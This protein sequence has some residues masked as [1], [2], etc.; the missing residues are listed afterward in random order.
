MLTV[1]IPAYNAEN[2]ISEQLE[3][4]K[5]QCYEGDWE[6]IVVNNGSTDN[7]V[8]IVAGY[9]QTMP[10]LKLAHALG[11]QS[12]GYA[13][14]RGVQNACGDAF[15]FCDADD[16]AAPNWIKAMAEALQT[17]DVVAGALEDRVLNQYSVWRPP[18][19][20]N[21]IQK[22][23][24]KNHLDFLPFALGCNLAISRDAFESVGG[25]VECENFVCEDVDLSWRLQ[26]QGYTIHY[27]PEAIMHYRF[28]TTY[29]AYWRQ[30]AA[31]A[32]CAPLLYKRF[33][34]YGMPEP[35]V[36][37]ALDRYIWVIKKFPRALVT[38]RK[39]VRSR[40][41]FK[42]AASWGRIQ[43]SIRHKVFYI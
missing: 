12:K 32:A 13:T 33:A 41:V 25:F 26:I 6:I 1:I 2:V 38:K 8:D 16:V 29:K 35:S 39:K 4:L 40:W 17:H 34:S 14:N 22:S 43:G 24:K 30:I 23:L 20:E 27:A 36:N 3:A 37:E 42:A 7:T 11:K 28:R 31:Y 15:V 21:Q 18:Q 10:N 5:A 9:Q 19:T